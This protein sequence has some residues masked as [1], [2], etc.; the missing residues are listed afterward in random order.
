M[1]K[2]DIDELKIAEVPRKSCRRFTLKALDVIAV[3]SRVKRLATLD[4]I[5]IFC[6]RRKMRIA[7]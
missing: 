7:G 5:F 1:A 2:E 4:N 6:F 3:D